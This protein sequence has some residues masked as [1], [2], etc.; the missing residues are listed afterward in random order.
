MFASRTWSQQVTRSSRSPHPSCRT[1]SSCEVSGRRDSHSAQQGVFDE[2]FGVESSP[3]VNSIALPGR[4]ESGFFD[5]LSNMDG[6]ASLCGV[7]WAEHPA[8]RG[9]LGRHRSSHRRV[10]PDAVRGAG[11][12]LTLSSFRPMLE[13]LPTTSARFT[14]DKQPGCVCCVSVSSA[15]A[16]QAASGASQL[17]F[18]GVAGEKLIS[19]TDLQIS[20]NRAS[21]LSSLTLSTPPIGQNPNTS[22]GRSVPPG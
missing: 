2:T 18:L 5:P 6:A 1:C 19:K 3:L 11:S 17:P 15:C 12:E 9:S 10:R 7:R 22:L 16:F 14:C 4:P 13:Q 21:L 8:D 20:K